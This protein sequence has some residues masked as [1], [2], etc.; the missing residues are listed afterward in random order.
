MW[1]QALVDKTRNV[2]VE[3]DTYPVRSTQKHGLKQ[4]DFRVGGRE[5][6]RLEQNPATK[7]RWAAMARAG[8]KVSAL[9]QRVTRY[10]HA[11]RILIS[12][13]DPGG[14]QQCRAGRSNL[15]M[16]PSYLN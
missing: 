1:Q 14:Q 7:S 6:R 16:I 10:S 8:Q 4:V 2:S 15:V 3:G 13:L 12:R 9:F 5:I 11:K